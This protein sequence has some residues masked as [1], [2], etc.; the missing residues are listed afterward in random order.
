MN[1]YNYNNMSFNI[2]T[3][4]KRLP[5]MC[6][7]IACD[8]E[9]YKPNVR[10]HLR[11]KRHNMKILLNDFRDHFDKESAAT[12]IELHSEICTTDDVIK[13]IHIKRILDQKI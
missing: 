8:E 3:I 5:T 2:I 9:L 11:S 7:C 13:Y 4:D 1:R 12:F 10:N 6:L